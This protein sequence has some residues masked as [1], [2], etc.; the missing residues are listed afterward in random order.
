M[1]NI[2]DLFGFYKP[3]EGKYSPTNGSLSHKLA[4]IPNTSK[5]SNTAY[6]LKYL[7]R[8]HKDHNKRLS[9]LFL[10]VNNPQRTVYRGDFLNNGTRVRFRLIISKDSGILTLEEKK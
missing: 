9:A 4:I 3:I 10:E 5:R 7:N 2:S 1:P 6:A 8:G